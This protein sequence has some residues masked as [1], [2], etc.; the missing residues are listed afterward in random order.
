MA[1]A[2]RKRRWPWILAVSVIVVSVAALWVDRQLEPT[3]LTATVLARAGEALGL[4]FSIDGTPEYALRPEPRL[5]LPGLKVRQPGAEAPWL[6]RA[7][8][9]EVSLPW[10][11]LTGGDSLVITRLALARPE[12][13]LAAFSAWQATR[14][15]SGPFEL[16][17]FTNGLEIK[18]GR[19]FA[20]DW[21]LESIA[22]SL[23]TLAPGSPAAADLS[24]RFVQAAI[25]VSFEGAL[26]AERAG[27]DT[28]LELNANGRLRTE[29]LD[30]PWSLALAG[31]LDA[32]TDTTT[33]DI[34]TLDWRSESPLP[35]LSASG[36]VSSGEALAL[37]LQGELPR[38]PSGWPTLPEPMAS[39]TSPLAFELVYDGPTDLVAP[40]ELQL[41][42]DD[43][44]LDTQLV[45]PEVLA[46]LDADSA[47]PL[48]PLTGVLSTPRLVIGGAT[49]EGLRITL[50]DAP[51]PP[52]G[53][54]SVPIAESIGTEVPPTG[55]DGDE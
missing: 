8:R 3:R 25:E 38:W 37:Q 46:W 31:R 40:L 4:E 50:D 51:A 45:L 12:L 48:P 19:V 35:D 9:A 42:R 49:L 15:P 6:L 36:K 43:T 11:T 52:V 18:D 23:P 29:S 30:A 41:R 53:G 26:D 34:S 39:A 27:L 5:V 22:L 24:G 17:T 20:P 21:A 7:E 33:L 13:D 44:L 54:T 2:R 47:N 10:D 1:D 14:P 16:P 28:P 32:R 55:G